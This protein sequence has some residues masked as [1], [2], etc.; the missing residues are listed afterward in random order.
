MITTSFWIIA[1]GPDSEDILQTIAE[2]ENHSD[3]AAAIVGAAIVEIYLTGALKLHLHEKEKLTK[4]FF[5][6]TGPVGDFGPKADLA[7]LVGII[8]D[9]THRDLV[10][11]INIRNAFAH[12]L[13]VRDFNSD[14]PKTLSSNLKIVEDRTWEIGETSGKMPAECW[15]GLPNREQILSDPRKRFLLAAQL[16]SVGFM[17]ISKRRMPSPAF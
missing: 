16:F 12:S 14:K 7:F 1:E 4:V 8:G 5:S 6:R 13:K 15:I 17:R 11:I 10:T 2:L 3:R 9:R